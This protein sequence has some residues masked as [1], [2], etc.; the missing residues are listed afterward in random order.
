MP[1]S[2]DD[3]AAEAEYDGGTLWTRRR[4]MSHDPADSL[5][6]QINRQRLGDF[7]EAESQALLSII[8]VYV[9]K[10][11]LAE[12]SGIKDVAAELLNSVAVQALEYA[13]R[14]DES[15]QP[16]AWLLGIA[17]NLVSRR[18]H[19]VFGR[20]ERESLASEL[21]DDG[22]FFDR[23]AS[24]GASPLDELSDHDQVQAMLTLVGEKEQRL[25]TMFV[26]EGMS[27]AEIAHKVGVKP[28]AIRVRLHRALKHIRERL[29]EKT[30][31]ELGRNEREG[32]QQ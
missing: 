1:F 13:D 26:F 29:A 6:L 23:V 27:P 5:R 20:R 31:H 16:R 10:A 19:E 7:I 2:H 9:W 11:G 8:R 32:S 18:Q 28:G 15:R 22:N 17:A 25:L 14:F 12:G 24:A 21:E 4:L 30:G 3:D